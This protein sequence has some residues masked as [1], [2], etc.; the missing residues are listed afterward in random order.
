MSEV[1]TVH[2][3]IGEDFGLRIMEIAQEH[4][5]YNYNPKKAIEMITKS[6][7]GCPKDLALQILLGEMVLPVDMETQEVICVPREKGIHDHFPQIDIPAWYKKKHNDIGQNGRLIY[8]NLELLMR[9]LSKNQGQFEVN[10]DYKSIV[11]FAGGN[12]D[13]V[14]EDLKHENSI[15]EIEDVI[16]ITKNYLDTTQ[17]VWAV[18]DWMKVTYPKYFELQFDKDATEHII[19]ERHDVVDMVLTR[20]TEFLNVDYTMFDKE[21]DDLNKYLDATKEIDTLLSAGIEPVDILDGYDAG[22]L[23][24]DGTYYGLN[25]EIANMLHN[26]IGS[27]LYDAGIIPE[28]EEN[29]QNPYAWLE[30]NG[31]IKLQNNHVYYGGYDYPDNIVEITKEQIDAI[32]RYGQTCH[33]GMLKVG[34]AQHLMS[35][36]MFGMVDP[37]QFKMKWF[38]F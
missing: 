35:A 24:P 3:S 14:L 7:M 36:A 11:D 12:V 10:F 21:M 15:N 29:E 30:K 4:L 22:W 9:D 8:G 28:G 1:K 5:L 32:V 33:K 19:T 17:K 20:L 37:I 26:Q 34:I 2:F 38:K 25:G 27:A 13:P 23:S 31:W 18:M 6:L 16:R